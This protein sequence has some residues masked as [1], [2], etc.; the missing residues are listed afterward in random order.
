[1]VEPSRL[2]GG[3]S[4]RMLQAA[5]MRAL[6]DPLPEPDSAQG[7]LLSTCDIVAREIVARGIAPAK[8]LSIY[9]K[10]TETNF[11][12]SLRLSFPATYRL[13]GKDYFRHCARLYQLQRPSC[14]G[15]LHHVGEAFAEYLAQLH[16]HDRY[17]YIGDIARLE[18]LCQQSLLAADRSPL[19]LAKLAA[20][21]LSDYDSL[22]FLLHPSVRLFSSKFP[23]QTIWQAN[24]ADDN[25]SENIDLDLAS[26]RGPEYL[27]IFRDSLGLL[28]QGLNAC[29]YSFLGNLQRG[30]TFTT[31][32]QAA[33]TESAAFNPSDSLRRWVA[34]RVIVDFKLMR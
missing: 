1:M 27:L 34:M 25:T 33:N 30:E 11:A 21:D 32:V 19:D 9:R 26:D 17:C 10:N 13:V 8:R 6:L 28:L 23:C 7:S 15:D 20:V 31:A 14:S 3:E 16:A 12:A 2:A 4:L 18:W 24:T 22:C 5:F 29:E